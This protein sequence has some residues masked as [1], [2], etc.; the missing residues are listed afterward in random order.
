VKL[1]V[2]V[3]LDNVAP[4]WT[5]REVTVVALNWTKAWS[6]EKRLGVLEL[7]R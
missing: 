3:A 4:H 5:A 2:A 6:A 1:T 7:V